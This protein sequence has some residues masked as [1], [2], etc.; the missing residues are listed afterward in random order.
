[1][2]SE[3][4]KRQ[5]DFHAALKASS[6]AGFIGSFSVS[7]SGAPWAAAGGEA[8]ED[9]YLVEDFGALGAL[10]EGVVSGG[11]S[12]PH[13]AAA[14]AALGGT[15]GLYSLRLGT[16]LPVPQKA[17]W[18]SKPAGM[19]YTEL[20]G[21]LAPIVEREGGA[22]WMRQMT[23]GPAREFCLQCPKHISLP[24]TFQALSISLRPVWP[25]PQSGIGPSHAS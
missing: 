7:L 2:E 13:G 6:P 25:R 16:V 5:R 15:A 1:M 12:G 21:Y 22:L 20:L 23:L 10:N 24:S 3:Y 8:Y 17:L 19:A 14:A 18:L 9:W 4:E 11:R